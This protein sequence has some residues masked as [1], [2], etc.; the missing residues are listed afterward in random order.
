[1]PLWPF[2]QWHCC[3]STTLAGGAASYCDRSSGAFRTAGIRNWGRSE[4]GA[5]SGRKNPPACLC[6]CLSARISPAPHARSLLK[7]C[8]MLPMAVARSFSGMLTIGRIAYRREGG[9]G[10]A[11]SGRSVIYCFLVNFVFFATVE[12]HKC[13]TVMKNYQSVNHT[14]HCAFS[15]KDPVQ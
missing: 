9:D 8:C 1:M 4:L 12:Q 3:S 7:F 15:F 13:L 5:Q 2:R 6:V 11:Q 14:N 10:S